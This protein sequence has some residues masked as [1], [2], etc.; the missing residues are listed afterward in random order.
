L[1][2][3]MMDSKF[4]LNSI[5]GQLDFFY[6]KLI[7]SIKEKNPTIFKKGNLLNPWYSMIGKTFEEFRSS[8]LRRWR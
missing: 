8:E 4:N 7:T 1:K 2:D 3:E 6:S 5:F